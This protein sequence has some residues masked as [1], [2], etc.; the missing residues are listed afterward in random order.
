MV[1]G[2]RTHVLGLSSVRC[3]GM[4]KVRSI[5]HVRGSASL[6][7]AGGRWMDMVMS[8]FEAIPD[9]DFDSAASFNFA[10]DSSTSL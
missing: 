1:E 3:I 5:V 6:D 7:G 8:V 9:C 2:P 4:S 10:E